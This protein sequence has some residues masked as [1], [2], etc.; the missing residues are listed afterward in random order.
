MQKLLDGNEFLRCQHGWLEAYHFIIRGKSN[1]RPVCLGAHLKVRLLAVYP[2]G[3]QILA[4]LLD[5]RLHALRSV[6]E[7]EILYTCM[8]VCMYVCMCVCM[9]VCMYVCI[10]C[11]Y[12]CA[13]VRA[14]VRMAGWMAGWMDAG[15]DG[16]MD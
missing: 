12:V 13:C 16:W 9:Y 4:R 14:C 3:H 2:V 7:I 11:V 6:P 1:C 15:R 10:L 5:T 8:Y